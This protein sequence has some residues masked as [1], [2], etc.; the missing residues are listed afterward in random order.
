[1]QIVI[2]FILYISKKSNN[3]LNEALRGTVS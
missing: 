2:L 1:M 3:I